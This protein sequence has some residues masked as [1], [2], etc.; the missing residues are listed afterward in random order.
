MKQIITCPH[1]GGIVNPELARLEAETEPGI[2][3]DF[4]AA[5]SETFS[6]IRITDLTGDP[7]HDWPL[8]VARFQYSQ[9]DLVEAILS[10]PRTARFVKRKVNNGDVLSPQ[11]A[12]SQLWQDLDAIRPHLA[13]IIQAGQ[14]VYGHQSRIA[15][16]LGVP[17]VGNYRRRIL[18]VAGALERTL[19]RNSNNSNQGE[20]PRTEKIAENAR[21]RAA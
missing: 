8:I 21:R 20:S 1:C 11:I 16:A 14:F 12:P 7:F 2:I 3:H 6:R 17:N 15:E 19:I 13:K 5:E 10:D 9:P 4:E 18:N